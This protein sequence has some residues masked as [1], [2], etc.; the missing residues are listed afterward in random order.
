MRS[1]A[2]DPSPIK[3]DNMSIRRTFL[4][5]AMAVLMGLPH[6]HAA[7]LAG[8]LPADL[9]FGLQAE[10]FK[11]REEAQQGLLDW[12]R[13]DPE[14]R[15]LLILRQAREAPDPEVRQRSHNVLHAL[16]MD[17]YLKAGEGFVGI[18]MNAIRAQVPG[19]GAEPREVIVISRVL[20]GTPA[21]E[22]GL[23]VGDMIASVNGRNL[24]PMDALASFQ[25]TIRALKPGTKASFDVIR[26]DEILKVDLTL[27]RRPPEQQPR[28]FGQEIEDMNDLA[29]RDQERFFKEWLENLEK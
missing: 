20:R 21:R 26:N 1:V 18:Q 14:A 13:L 29:K 7:A 23:R 8:E 3:P 11:V 4:V 5:P 17:E 24:A 9:I 22:A 28:F 10:E 2:C 19:E 15:T 27:G 16:A 25:N 6:I 12:A